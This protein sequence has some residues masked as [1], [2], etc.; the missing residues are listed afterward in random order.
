MCKR[1]CSNCERKYVI[2]IMQL[3]QVGQFL[4]DTVKYPFIIALSIA[5]IAFRVVEFMFPMEIFRLNV[6]YLT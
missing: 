2:L 1:E 5:V 4:P 6:Q 3:V